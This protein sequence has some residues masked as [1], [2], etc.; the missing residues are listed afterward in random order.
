[1]SRTHACFTAWAGSFKNVIGE[2]WTKLPD[3]VSYLVWQWEASP[4]TGN[5]H[6]QGYAEFNN[7]IRWTAAK[8]RLGLPDETHFENRAGSPKQASD[9]CKKPERLSGPWELGTISNGQGGRTDLKTVYTMAKEGK[10][11]I[12]IG[13]A[14][15]ETAVVRYSASINRIRS[16]AKFNVLTERK[17]WCFI[18]PTQT[19]KS[20]RAWEE[21]TL[22]AFPK[23]EGQW[24]DGYTSE[25]NAVFDDFSG[26]INIT[27]M[28]KILDKF[29]V[30][31]PIKG[32]FTSWKAENI[33][34]TSNLEPEQWYP[35]A[36]P[37]QIAALKRR[38][39][40]IHF[41]P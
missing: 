3:G 17:C 25:R 16:E 22:E 12:E 1:M 23:P 7:K 39:T 38:M 32:G 19:G 33:W 13:D 14:G 37:G 9:Y 41:E 34:I 6:M 4:S 31:V 24:F 15:L 26:D 40:I 21:A 11:L 20:T 5:I 30:K 10:S 29:P 36:T 35:K 18:G 8:L 28:L 27:Q 2:N